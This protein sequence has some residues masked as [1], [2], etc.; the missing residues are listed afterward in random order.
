VNPREWLH[1]PTN[2]AYRFDDEHVD[3]NYQEEE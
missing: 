3:E 1:T 2:V